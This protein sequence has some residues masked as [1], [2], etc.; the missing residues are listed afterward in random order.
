MVQSQGVT[1][2]ALNSNA[3]ESSIHMLHTTHNATAMQHP[4]TSV[5]DGCMAQHLCGGSPTCTNTSAMLQP[6]E[7]FLTRP[8][9]GTSLRLFPDKASPR[10]LSVAVCCQELDAN[11]FVTI[12]DECVNRM[13]T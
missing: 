10:R 9:H 13:H 5:I 11:A 7:W 12:N 8:K 2:L 1:G 6:S 4:A 3:A